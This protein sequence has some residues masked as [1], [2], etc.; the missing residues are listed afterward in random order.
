V[1]DRSDFRK[2]G[3]ERRDE[4]FLLF[5]RR[6]KRGW[7]MGWGLFSSLTHKF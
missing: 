1:F 2:D 5:G 4:Y 3:K 6:E 7:K